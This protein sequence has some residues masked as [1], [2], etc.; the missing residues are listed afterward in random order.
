VV[1]TIH[2][3][4]HLRDGFIEDIDS[5]FGF[6]YYKKISFE[7]DELLKNLKDLKDTTSQWYKNLMTAFGPDSKDHAHHDHDSDDHHSNE[8]SDLSSSQN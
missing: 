5:D 2:V 1:D 4:D 3:T 7:A 8:D 6:I